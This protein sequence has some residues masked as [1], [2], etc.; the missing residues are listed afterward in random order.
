[1]GGISS[2]SRVVDACNTCFETKEL[3]DFLDVALAILPVRLALPQRV[4][5]LE[6]L[7]QRECVCARELRRDYRLSLLDL[8]CLL[9][10]A[11]RSNRV[12]DAV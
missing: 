6:G 7:S 5:R 1:M 11:L 3:P 12:A 9:R 10:S 2:N 8:L 4:E